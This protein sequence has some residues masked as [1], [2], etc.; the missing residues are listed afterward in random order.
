MNRILIYISIY[1]V[2][3]L[4]ILFPVENLFIGYSQ[5]SIIDFVDPEV[6][7]ITPNGG[8]LLPNNEY[9][10]F[11]WEATDQFG[12]ME[13]GINFELSTTLMPELF[14]ELVSG[15]SNSYNTNILLP[16]VNTQYGKIKIIVFDSFGNSSK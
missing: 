1:T 4:S 6:E 8:E 7:L 2:F 11:S 13:G 14:N 16:D 3:T 9:S 10:T 15:I 5:P 12:I